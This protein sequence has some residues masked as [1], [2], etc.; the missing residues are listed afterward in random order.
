MRSVAGTEVNRFINPLVRMNL[1]S[2]CS[3]KA[4]H[5]NVN[6]SETLVVIPGFNDKGSHDFARSFRDARGAAKAFV[7]EGC[8]SNRGGDQPDA[9]VDDLDRFLE[10]TLP[11]ID[12]TVAG[13]SYGSLLALR[14]AC[15]RGMRRVGHL[16][17]IDG[18]LNPEVAVEPPPDNHFYDAFRVQYAERRRIATECLRAIGDM[19]EEIRS[20]IVTV[21]S[22]IDTVVPPAAKTIPG[23][24]HHA[25]APE[26]SG[27]SLSPDKIR[28]ITDFLVSEVFNL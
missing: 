5:G 18:P 16:V 24:R 22:T 21:G 28:A 4:M 23:I 15:R 14:L 6:L 10:E 3:S 2:V 9:I 27:H 20:R 12:L 19:P 26:I 17:L 25:L 13:D 11:G 7:L 8:P 1:G